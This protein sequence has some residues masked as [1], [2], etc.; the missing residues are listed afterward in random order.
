[1]KR[2]GFFTALAAGI[3]SLLVGAFLTRTI[4]A[5]GEADAAQSMMGGSMMSGGMMGHA[6]SADMR[7]YMDMFMHH[8][9]IRRTVEHISGGV[10][11]LTES[12]NPQIAKQ[13]QEHVSEMY[14]HVGAGQE[15]QCMS[16]NLPQ[17]FREAS[18]Y[19]RSLRLTPKGVSGSETSRDPQ[20]VKTIRAH[21]DEVSGF[22]KEG[23]PAMMRE[24]MR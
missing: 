24:M 4:T 19:Q 7:T 12:D 20:L 23:M 15:V 10:R 14:A 6:T 9:Q 18:R 13:L 3:G 1:M 11:T 21:A 16:P 17:M 8:T 5:G 22:V 2:K